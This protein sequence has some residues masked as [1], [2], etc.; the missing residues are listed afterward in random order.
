MEIA[1]TAYRRQEPANNANVPAGAFN[2]ATVYE[3]ASPDTTGI[4]AACRHGDS[5]YTSSKRGVR[6]WSLHSGRWGG[7]AACRGR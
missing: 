5:L 6:R 3:Y 4:K 2:W 7:R 1:A